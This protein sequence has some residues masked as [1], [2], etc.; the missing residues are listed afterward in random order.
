M[1][2][3]FDSTKNEVETS[4]S[5]PKSNLAVKNISQ[6][7]TSLYQQ[8][9]EIKFNSLLNS[10]IVNPKDVEHSIDNWTHNSL[11]KSSLSKLINVRNNYLLQQWTMIHFEQ[12]L[13][14]Y[15]EH[16]RAE[17]KE[18]YKQLGQSN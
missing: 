14:T 11:K 18:L 9:K 16:L 17:F 3:K 7:E 8:V 15:W 1:Y 10:Q 13:Q 2:S 5:S 4:Y 6:N 12:R